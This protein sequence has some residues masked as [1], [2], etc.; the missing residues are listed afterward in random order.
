MKRLRNFE[1]ICEV[2]KA[3]EMWQVFDD[4]EGEDDGDRLGSLQLTRAEVRDL[5]ALNGYSWWETHI[6]PGA[7][8]YKG[9]PG[10]GEEVVRVGSKFLVPTRT[11][12]K[13]WKE[14]EEMIERGKDKCAKF[15]FCPTVEEWSEMVAEAG[16]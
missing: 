13:A 3:S 14:R 6:G 15:E 16:G 2:V 9:S 7:K 10:S 1:E 12:E 11:D 4:V 5:L 8:H